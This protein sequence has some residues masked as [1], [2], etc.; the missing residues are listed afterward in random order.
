M[1]CMAQQALFCLCLY[2][3]LA[4]ETYHTGIT[5]QWF[6]RL[7]L[8]TQTHKYTSPNSSLS[9]GH[10]SLDFY[11]D[12]IVR[13]SSVPSWGDDQ[14]LPGQMSSVGSNSKNN[15]LTQIRTHLFSCHWVHAQAQSH[16]L[17]CPFQMLCVHAGTETRALEPCCLQLSRFFL[18]FLSLL[19]PLLT[20][21][22]CEI[23]GFLSWCLRKQ[24]RYYWGSTQLFYS[25]RDPMET[26]Y[27]LCMFQSKDNL[28]KREFSSYLFIKDHVCAAWAIIY[29]F[30]WWCYLDVTDCEAL[31]PSATVKFPRGNR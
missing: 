31:I 22:T 28:Q 5:I 30:S 29:A 25:P 26:V 10:C 13:C 6:C 2:S 20:S 9:V 23:L 27:S 18:Y 8:L 21:W 24:R 14:W 16:C 4:T 1:N 3:S 19:P 7:D 15:T 11:M 12:H 17:Y